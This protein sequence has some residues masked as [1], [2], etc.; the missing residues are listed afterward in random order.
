MYTLAPGLWGVI[1]P[2]RVH[3]RAWS[4]GLLLGLASLE[5]SVCC[6]VS[7][8]GPALGHCTHRDALVAG[9]QD[10]GTWLFPTCQCQPP[11][12]AADGFLCISTVLVAASL[13]TKCL[14]AAADAPALES[15]FSS[16]CCQ[17]GALSRDVR[18]WNP[19]AQIFCQ[20]W[21]CPAYKVAAA[22]RVMEIVLF[23]ARFMF[24]VLPACPARYW[25]P[26]WGEGA[27][28]PI[29]LC[30]GSDAP[31]DEFPG[32]WEGIMSSRD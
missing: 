15:C 4:Q 29:T 16:Q 32:L 10:G 11:P 25:R 22:T 8:G 24:C 30:Q 27:A 20:P 31:N 14:T 7:L 28:G 19:Q 1:R 5:C 23:P 26:L 6:G 13:G 2:C 21:L 9:P 17:R 3:M 18:G 12:A